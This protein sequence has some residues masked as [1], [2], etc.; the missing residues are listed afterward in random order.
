LENSVLASLATLKISIRG[1]RLF[2]LFIFG[3]ILPEGQFGAS[4]SNVRDWI[5]LYEMAIATLTERLPEHTLWRISCLLSSPQSTPELFALI[6]ARVATDYP[7]FL[8]HFVDILANCKTSHFAIKGLAHFEKLLPSTAF[9]RLQ[10]KAS[11]TTHP[12]ARPTTSPLGMLRWTMEAICPSVANS[13][14]AQS[15]QDTTN[16]CRPNLK[17]VAEGKSF[18]AHEGVLVPRWPLIF[19]WFFTREHGETTF[20]FSA[21][22]EPGGLTASALQGLLRYF[23]TGQLDQLEKRDD[24]VLIASHMAE[25]K[26]TTESCGTLLAYCWDRE[27]DSSNKHDK[28]SKDKC[29]VM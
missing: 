20:E 8:D 1:Q 28:N 6:A 14:N 15:A 29:R 3:D 11:L 13:M 25:L 22:T 5:E 19:T 23:Y 12:I 7:T 17:L 24:C 9:A 4:E 21:P 18:Y 26:L 16:Q 2:W 10:T 27:T